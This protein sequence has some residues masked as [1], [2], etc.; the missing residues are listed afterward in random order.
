MISYDAIIVA[1]GK[2]SRLSLGYNKVFYK[3]EDG[4]TILDKACALFI[5]DDDCKNIIVV[6]N[7]EEFHLVNHNPKLI[8][9]RGGKMR[10]DSVYEGLKVVKS[11]YVLIHDGARPKLEVEDLDKLKSSLI[12]NDAAIL[13]VKAKETIKLVIDSYISE[14][15]DRNKV[16]LAQTPQGFRYEIIKNAYDKAIDSEIEFTDDASIAEY[17]GIK[18]KIVEGSYSN[19]KIT[20]PSDLGM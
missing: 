14:T 5:E 13:A 6:T 1:S 12:E 18:V 9:V 3:Y 8:L 19:N 7:E 2:G 11:P 17:V 4:Q 15:I 10:K 20:Y 16:Y